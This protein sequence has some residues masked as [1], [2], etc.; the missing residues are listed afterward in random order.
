VNA[1]V[2]N[3]SSE[4]N[5]CQLDHGKHDHT[6]AIGGGA[7]PRRLPCHGRRVPKNMNGQNT[8]NTHANMNTNNVNKRDA[9]CTRKHNSSQPQA[10]STTTTMQSAAT[11]HCSCKVQSNGQTTATCTNAASNIYPVAPRCQLVF[12]ENAL[13]TGTIDAKQPQA[14]TNNHN[15][16]MHTHTHTHTHT[17][18]QNHITHTR[19]TSM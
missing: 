3:R 9:L 13:V 12:V 6:D 18:T 14:T 1:I 17:R 15:A 7:G 8:N 11:T 4:Y 16:T 5:R 10:A 2:A 19:A